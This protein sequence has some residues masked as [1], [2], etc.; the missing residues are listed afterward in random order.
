[1]AH[2]KRHDEQDIQ[3]DVQKSGENEK[4]EGRSAVAQ[5]PQQ[6][7]DEVIEDRG[8]GAQVNDEQVGKSH[9]VNIPWRVQ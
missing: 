7:G 3:H 4:D 9:V 1:M 2:A 8:P 6:V 5:G